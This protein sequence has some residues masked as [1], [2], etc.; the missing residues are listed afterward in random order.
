MVTGTSRYTADS[1][2]SHAP[3][4]SDR[5]D[6]LFLLN[7]HAGRPR[8]TAAAA[9]CGDRPA[10]AASC[11]TR[12]CIDDRRSAPIPLALEQDG[13]ACGSS[14]ATASSLISSQP[15]THGGVLPSGHRADLNAG[16]PSWGHY[17]AVSADASSAR[18]ELLGALLARSCAARIMLADVQR[19][20]SDEDSVRRHRA[21]SWTALTWS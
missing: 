9:L 19:H 15:R 14:A 12:C 20:P 2:C 11:P 8:I 6:N 4:A 18:E 5:G 7:K 13:A 10:S 16:P 21:L 3:A 17:L 1:R